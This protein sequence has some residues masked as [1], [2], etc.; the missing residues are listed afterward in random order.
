MAAKLRGS[1][2]ILPGLSF[3]RYSSMDAAAFFRFRSGVL[4]CSA[5][6]YSCLED[7][8]GLFFSMR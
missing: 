8:A 7:C 5:A 4:P 3:C 2:D 1:F 6:I